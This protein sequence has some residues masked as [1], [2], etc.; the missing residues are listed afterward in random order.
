METVSIV[1]YMPVKPMCQPDGPEIKRRIKARGY[2][3]AGFARKIRRPQSVDTI[4]NVCLANAVPVSVEMIRQIAAGLGT[5]KRPVKPSDISDW[6][7][8]DDLYEEPE[9]KALAS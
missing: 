7:G 6:T 2:T 3:M 9:P 8:D 4:R 5:P 1:R